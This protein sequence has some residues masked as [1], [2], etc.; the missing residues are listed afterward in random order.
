MWGV[1]FALADALAFIGGLGLHH[2][3]S[4]YIYELYNEDLRPG[5]VSEKNWGLFDDNG[6]PVYILHLTGSGT[7]LANDTTN[8]TYCVAKYG[9]NPKLLQAALDW[10]CGPGKVDCSALMQG[11]LCY[12]PDTVAAHSTYAFD[13]YYHQMAMAPGTCYFNG[14]ATVTTTDP[15]HGSCKFP[16]SGGSNGTVANRTAFAPSANSI[17]SGDP[18]QHCCFNELLIVGVLLSVAVLL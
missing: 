3:V 2:M 6:V 10:A 5:S 17:S 7:V 9:A 13:A 14:V 11:G 16:G 4:T 18:P 8:Q 15:S 1:D 12:E